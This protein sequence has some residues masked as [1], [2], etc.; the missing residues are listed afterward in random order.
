MTELVDVSRIRDLN[1]QL[2]R[3]LTGGVLVMTKGIIALGAKRQMTI[4]SAI[5][6]FDDFSPENDPYLARAFRCQR[7]VSWRRQTA[8]YAD[9]LD[10]CC[11][12][13][14]KLTD[15]PW[16]IMSIGLCDWAHRF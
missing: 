13:W 6:A 15:Q 14:N 3:S 12:A 8:S 5:A 9:I 10:H 4:L 7:F 11:A 2:R 16:L 1:D